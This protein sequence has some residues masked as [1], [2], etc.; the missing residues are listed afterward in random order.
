MLALCAGSLRGQTTTD[1]CY[2]CL[3]RSEAIQAADS[4]LWG[5]S[6]ARTLAI[7]RALYILRGNDVAD[8]TGINAAKDVQVEALKKSLIMAQDMNAAAA[9]ELRRNKG[10][11]TRKALGWILGALAS[12]YILHDALR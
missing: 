12:G 11:A 1:T 3:T 4:A 6:A 8:L 10:K 5:Q 9:K 2:I 7:T